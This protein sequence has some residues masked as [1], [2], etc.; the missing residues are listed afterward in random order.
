MKKTQ[1]H[2]ASL[3]GF[4]L[5]ILGA[6]LF[7]FSGLVLALS[8]LTT[9]FVK[10]QTDAHSAIFFV[11]FS[12][13]GAI[14]VTASIIAFLKFLNKPAAE[15]PMSFSLSWWQIALGIIGSGL[16]L[17]IGSQLQTLTS[18]NWIVLP[19]LTLAAVALP[20]WTILGMGT[21]NTLRSS[22]WRTWSVLGLSM[23]LVPVLLLIVELLIALVIILMVT[24]YIIAQPGAAAE[25]QS[26]LAQL[27]YINPESSETLKLLIPFV[28]KPGT[29]ITILIYLAVLVPLV[30]ELVKPLGV[31]M[32]GGKL[33]SASQGFALGALSG[34]GYAL[35]ETTNVSGQVEEWGS[36]LFTRIGTGLLHVTTSALMGAAIVM[37]WRERRYLRLLGTYLI[38]IFLHGLWNTAAIAYG[39]STLTGMFAQENQF[40]SLHLIAI[41]S[42]SVLTVALLAT[43]LTTNYKLKRAAPINKI[44]ESTPMENTNDE[45][46][47]VT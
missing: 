36:L 45:P 32:L 35:A 27:R 7:F 43:L 46:L 34:A 15:V 10:N 11:A 31:W 18:V 5:F 17:W 3:F 23:T 42:M 4:L 12:F 19:F 2:L 25:F 40:R 38:A 39:F 16:S 14:L 30:E 6:V 41:I 37:A 8:A 20:L 22:R 44:Q 24:V 28:T 33:N 9:F 13:E 1:T 21:R 47:T 26:L 29:V